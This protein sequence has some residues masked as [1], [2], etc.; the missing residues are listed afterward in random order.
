LPAERVYT[1]LNRH[2]LYRPATKR[3]TALSDEYRAAIDPSRFQLPECERANAEVVSFHHRLL[4]GD[5]R[6]MA[7]VVS[8][9]HKVWQHL[10]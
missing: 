2:P 10:G 4:L 3:T 6:D 9:F 5:D 7:D 1:P 8:A